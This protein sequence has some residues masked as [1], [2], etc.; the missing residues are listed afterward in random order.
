MAS[1]QEPQP[2]NSQI[3]PT[4]TLRDQDEPTNREH[5]ELRRLAEE[6]RASWKRLSAPLHRSREPGES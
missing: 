6:L 1:D 3:E 4:G 2:P 5:G